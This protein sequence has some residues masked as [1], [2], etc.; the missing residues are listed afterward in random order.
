M[1][2]KTCEQLA[3]QGDQARFVFSI[4]LA[5]PI[6]ATVAPAI[7]ATVLTAIPIS[8]AVAISTAVVIATAV[9]VPVVSRIGGRGGSWRWLWRV[10]FAFILIIG[11]CQI[12]VYA[13]QPIGDYI[14]LISEGIFDDRRINRGH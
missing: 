4:I 6:T 7:A 14:A 1:E 9:P 8:T 12:W 10:P 2:L 5:V 3:E 11:R 13:R